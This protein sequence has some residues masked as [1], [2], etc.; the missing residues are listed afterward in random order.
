MSLKLKNPLWY[1]IGAQLCGIILGLARK[2]IK[3]KINYC[4]H[5]ITQVTFKAWYE[6]KMLCSAYIA[7]SR[8]ALQSLQKYI[9]L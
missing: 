1:S 7:M 9:W 3:F 2:K 6:L 5:L 8:C 4:L